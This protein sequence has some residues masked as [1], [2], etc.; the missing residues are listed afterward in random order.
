MTDYVIVGAGSA[1]CV[2]AEA[3]S[4]RHS[5]V[6]LEAGGTDRIPEVAIPAAYSKLFRTGNDWAYST[7]EEPGAMDRRLFLPRGKMVGGSSSMNAQL[8]VRGRPSD[9]DSWVELG[10]VGWGWDSVASVFVR[11][12]RNTRGAGPAHGDAGPLFVSD[13]RSINPLSRRFVAAAMAA[14]IPANP[15]FND[16]DQ[17]GVGYFQVTQRR[18]RRWSAADAFLR[19]ALR[20]PT[21]RLVTNVTATRVLF[22]RGRAIGVEGIQNGRTVRFH[23]DAEVIVSCGAFGSPHLLQLSGVGNPEHLRGVGIEPVHASPQVG[24][25]LQDH[26][27]VGAIY[28]SLVAGTLDDAENA[29]EM[30]SWV[31][32][33]RGRLTSPVAEAAAFVRSSPDIDEPNLQ[34]H[35]GPVNFENHG[36]ERYDG[37]GFSIGPVL[38]NPRAR[39]SVRALSPD[40]R[41]HP[42]IL[43]NSLTHRADVDALVAGVELAREIAAQSP[44]REIRGTELHPGPGEPDLERFVRSRVELL[45]HPV[46][47]CRMGS[48]DGAVVDPQLRVRGIAGLRII[49]ASVMPRVTSG[50]TNAPTMMIASRGAELILGQ[51]SNGNSS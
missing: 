1:G 19:P 17:T 22:D 31:L 36:M 12:E 34:F 26:P 23:A 15:D 30:A 42:A 8:Y 45:Y 24:E 14:G 6:L 16:G 38:V 21:L 43:T 18:G 28:D 47:T 10:A 51:S 11:M 25:N 46:G 48:D 27:V 35:F 4:A 33:R 13:Q 5:V 40:P 41:L 49:D 20:R 44:L 29:V 7:E 3:L 50:N 37:H 39:G 2:L 32:L 9:Y